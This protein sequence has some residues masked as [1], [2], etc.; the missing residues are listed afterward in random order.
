VC[1]CCSAAIFSGFDFCAK[2]VNDNLIWGFS[3]KFKD[4][5][6]SDDIKIE[7]ISLM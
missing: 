2:D 7:F 3:D 4:L 1:G 6:D 5:V